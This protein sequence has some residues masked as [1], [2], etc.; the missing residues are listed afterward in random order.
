MEVNDCIYKL[1]KLCQL[2]SRKCDN[3]S[4]CKG[5]HIK[6]NKEEVVHIQTFKIKK[7]N[8]DMTME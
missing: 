8:I 5:F 6:E 3:N 7:H 1:D 2:Y 4:N